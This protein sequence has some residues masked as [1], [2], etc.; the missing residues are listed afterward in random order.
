M[1]FVTQIVDMP[2]DLNPNINTRKYNKIFISY[3]HQDEKKVKYIAEA[4]KAQ[5]INY[6][7]D[8]HYLKGG[9]VFPLQI[10]EY[11]I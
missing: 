5:G 4:Y 8:R 3:A 7:F 1:R 2:L 11:I 6:F 10:Q 9:D